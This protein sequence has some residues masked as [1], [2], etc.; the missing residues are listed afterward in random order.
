MGEYDEIINQLIEE[1][2]SKS[3]KMEE[4]EIEGKILKKVDDRLNQKISEL[5][6]KLDESLKGLS[7]SIRSLERKFEKAK[8]KELK[9]SIEFLKEVFGK[10]IEEIDEKLKAIDKLSSL[11]TQINELREHLKEKKERGI[12]G[13]LPELTPHEEVTRLL[14]LEKKVDEL[15][16][17]VK[18]G[19]INR[20]SSLESATKLLEDIPTIKSE[21]L[22]IKRTIGKDTLR[23]ISEIINAEERDL[24]KMVKKE[25]ESR[26]EPIEEDVLSLRK[27]FK[28]IKSKMEDLDSKWKELTLI[29]KRIE[30]IRN[31]AIKL[32]VDINRKF[33][34]TL[35][36]FENCE[37]N[38]ISFKEKLERLGRVVADL[39]DSY[40]TMVREFEREIKR[41]KSL[42]EEIKK[43]GFMMM[44]N[45]EKINILENLVKELSEKSMLNRIEN[46]KLEIIKL[47]NRFASL[48][49]RVNI[50][51]KNLDEVRKMIDNLNEENKMVISE[52]RDAL[53]LIK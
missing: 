52:L 50:L 37:K 15:E 4:R 24:P 51:E 35:K 46:I 31:H 10:K 16:K 29:K 13:E 48:N 38:I 27:K 43:L 44:K 1:I 42:E 36:A 17:F 19:L 9:E 14:Q 40:E 39:N 2:S 41:T 34:T 7:E 45:K 5:D 11:E 25:V 6:K 8:P 22:E 26:F 21:M 53:E 28:E 32:E 30:E 23:K 18:E 20:I 33:S 47:G 3:K 49:S 12:F